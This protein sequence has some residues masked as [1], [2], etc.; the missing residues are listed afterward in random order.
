M[1]NELKPCPFCGNKYLWLED[2][3]IRGTARYYVICT[4]C[5]AKSNFEKTPEE[6]M[7]KW[8][9]RGEQTCSITDL[10]SGEVADYECREHIKH[11]ESC[12]HDFGYVLYNEDGD[13][14]MDEQ[15]RFCPNCGAKVV[16]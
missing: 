15:P 7:K 3:G 5:G 6:A 2:I 10:N 8:N 16:E 11:C 13:T 1:S 12:H 4:T 14:W 9:E